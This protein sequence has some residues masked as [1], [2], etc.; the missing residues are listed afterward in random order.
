MRIYEADNAYY[1][2]AWCCECIFLMMQLV[3]NYFHGT[4][5]LRL[6]ACIPGHVGKCKGGCQNR[7]ATVAAVHKQLLVRLQQFQLVFQLLNFFFSKL[8][9]HSFRHSLS[10]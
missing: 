5:T 1:D 6:S 2:K 10:Y 3:V 4:I 8:L 9:F 7:L